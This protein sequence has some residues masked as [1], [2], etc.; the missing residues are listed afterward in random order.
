MHAGRHGAPRLST[1]SDGG[2]TNFFTAPGQIGYKV[3]NS[4]TA[5]NVTI[6]LNTDND[7]DP[8]AG[9]VLRYAD[10]TTF[11]NFTGTGVPDATWFA[12]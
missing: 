2:F 8:E 5:Y 12:L 11:V 7:S 9:I 10:V 6:W 4:T 1:V 3:D